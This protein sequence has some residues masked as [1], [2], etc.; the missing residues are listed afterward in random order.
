MA[1]DRLGP[2][3]RSTRLATITLATPP[4]PEAGRDRG[5]HR[6]RIIDLLQHAVAQHDVGAGRLDQIRKLVT[7]ALQRGDRLGD[8]G[9]RARRARLASASGLASMTVTSWPASASGHGETAGAAADVDDVQP[10]V[11]TP[12]HLGTQGRPDHRRARCRCRCGAGVVH[13]LSLV[14]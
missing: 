13:A 4:R 14:D 11:R 5:H 1:G 3:P 6:G 7:V 10:F 12:V 8:A 9:I 2:A